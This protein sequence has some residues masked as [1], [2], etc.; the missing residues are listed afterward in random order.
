MSAWWTPQQLA[1]LMNLRRLNL[2][3][4]SNL[5]RFYNGLKY[6]NDLILKM[7]PMGGSTEIVHLL[8][9]MMKDEFLF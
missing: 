5:F 7:R 6:E 4:G 3:E 2:V 8:S 9:K 1:S